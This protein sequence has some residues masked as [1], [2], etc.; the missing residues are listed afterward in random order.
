MSEL[1]QRLIQDPI[2]AAKSKWEQL[3]FWKP[4]CGNHKAFASALVKI[5]ALVDR[6]V[7]QQVTDELHLEISIVNTETDRG[8]RAYLEDHAEN[9]LCLAEVADFRR[10]LQELPLPSLLD[11]T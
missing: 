2:E 6:V 9:L 8:V 10:R 4:G 1:Q 3:R 5:K 11:G 7:D